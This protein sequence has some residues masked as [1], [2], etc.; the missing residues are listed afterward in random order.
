MNWLEG[1]LQAELQLAW[2]EGSASLSEGPAIEVV[3]GSS[4]RAGQQEVGVVE[5]IESFRAELS[6]Y[7]FR[8]ADV[9]E[10]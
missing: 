8:D 6:V 2:I 5:H 1:H 4:R 3:V 9:L 7:S 10:Q